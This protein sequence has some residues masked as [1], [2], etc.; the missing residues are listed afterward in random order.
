MHPPNY[1]RGH[2]FEQIVEQEIRR[3]GIKT[4]EFT[5]TNM[6]VFSKRSVQRRNFDHELTNNCGS[7]L[8]GCTMK[9][10]YEIKQGRKVEV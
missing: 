7:L 8:L 1:C 9:P 2:N 6:H 10:I 5:M 3:R 4:Y